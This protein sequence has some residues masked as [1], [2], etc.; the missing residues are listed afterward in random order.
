MHY[1][2]W[3]KPDISVNEVIRS[4]EFSNYLLWKITEVYLKQSNSKLYLISLCKYVTS[5]FLL[6]SNMYHKK[7]SFIILI[8]NHVMKQLLPE[9]DMNCNKIL[10]FWYSVS[11]R[12]CPVIRH[13]H[14]RIFC[15]EQWRLSTLKMQ[16]I[17]FT[18]HTEKKN[19]HPECWANL[20]YNKLGFFW[21]VSK[22]S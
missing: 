8:L 5:D 6:A 12:I 2:N 1:L 7:Y 9:N 18:K 17:L 4:L 13:H 10:L 14:T 3:I 20:Y 15:N 16:V 22:N 19:S 21:G 11:N